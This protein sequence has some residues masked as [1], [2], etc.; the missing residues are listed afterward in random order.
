MANLFR[1]LFER[2]G[3]IFEYPKETELTGFE[4][5]LDCDLDDSFRFLQDAKQPT[6]DI[7]DDE[8]LFLNFL[9]GF[10]DAEGSIW[11]H[12][13]HW[14]GGAFEVSVVNVDKALMEIIKAKLL[15][16]GFH[17]KLR[18][19]RQRPNPRVNGPIA[20]L[21]WRLQ[22]WRYDD[23]SRFLRIV[24]MRHQEKVKKASIALTLRSWSSESER[25]EVLE[26]W[27]NLK[28]QIAK[29]VA[30]YIDRARQTMEPK[31]ANR[32]GGA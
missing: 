26:R 5:C 13:K 17:P 32:E 2:Y 29:D 24:P 14:E 1:D 16:L 31:R 22:L 20:E 10:F 7:L 18:F 6:A 4:W 9:A 19:D 28:S 15:D 25:S 12:R 21:I 27:T 30:T 11:Y 8:T 23:V 3:P